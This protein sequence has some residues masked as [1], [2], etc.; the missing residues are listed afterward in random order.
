[1]LKVA[2]FRLEENKKQALDIQLVKSRITLQE[3]GEESTHRFL[4]DPK[5]RED[6]ILKIMDGRK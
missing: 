2:H 1:M 3:F 5:Y 6:F 4:T